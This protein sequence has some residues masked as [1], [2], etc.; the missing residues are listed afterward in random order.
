M[1]VLL[2]LVFLNQLVNARGL[3]AV[4]DGVPLEFLAHNR[5][6]RLQVSNDSVH[7]ADRRVDSSL[8]LIH[9]V[10]P[11]PL[12]QNLQHI[13]LQNVHDVKLSETLV[14]QSLSL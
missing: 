2:R 8:E 1:T 13:R 9:I 5:N 6:A 12:V 14:L 3:Q 4:V 10:D 7:V 11:K